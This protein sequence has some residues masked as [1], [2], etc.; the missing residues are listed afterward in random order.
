MAEVLVPVIVAPSFFFLVGWAIWMIVQWRQ[1]KYRMN[2]QLK[3]LD[4]VTSGAEL[5][6]FAASKAGS[7]FIASMELQS[8]GIRDRI[9]SA[10]YKAVILL[11]L[12]GVIFALRGTLETV[13]VAFTILGSLLMALGLGYIVATVLSYRL[14]LRWGM[15]PAESAS[16]A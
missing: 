6:Q 12:G 9:I 16:E 2:I 13:T 4:K 1:Y 14:A 8:V 3:M 15:I 5:I 11:G 10:V 7:R